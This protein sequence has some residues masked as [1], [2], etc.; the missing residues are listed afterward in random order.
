MQSHLTR[1]SAIHPALFAIIPIIT[2]VSLNLD[3]IFLENS[4]LLFLVIVPSVLVLWYLLN[5]LI[6]DKMKSGLLLSFGLVLFFSYGHFFNVLRDVVIEDLA[7]GRHRYLL[8]SFG[9][10]F[11]VGFYSIL[12]TKKNFAEF[13]TIANVI[14]IVILL[15]SVSNM[16]VYV[17]E[18]NDDNYDAILNNRLNYDSGLTADNLDYTPNV[19]YIIMDKYTSSKVLKDIFDFD[20]QDFTSQLSARGFHVIENSHSNYASTF[21]SLTSSLNMEYVN[22]LTDAVGI[23]SSNQKLSYQLYSDNN[24]MN[25]FKALNYTLVSS[26]PSSDYLALSGYEMCTD[27]L[28]RSQLNIILW[29][30]TILSPIFT[31]I[32][33]RFYAD[34]ILCQFSELSNLH[35][36]IEEPF[37]AYVHFLL[38]HQP[39]VFDPLG[40]FKEFQIN[41]ANTPQNLKLDYIDQV[42][43]AN[44][45]VIETIDKIL[46]ESDSPPIILL[47]GDHGTATLL[48][49]FGENW[50]NKNNESMTERMS[51][52]NAYYLPDQNTE[53]IIY[54]SITP[55]N[56]FRLILNAYF[57]TNYELL[58]DK[59]YFSDY[60]RPYNFTDVTKI[61]LTNST[62]N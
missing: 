8:P 18:N 40:N 1:S 13:T 16:F 44:K 46:L 12:K 52:L 32:S 58:E 56:S 11:A 38:P 5:L 19:Y 60:V 29:E 15:V 6:K 2:I 23:D 9:I 21:L 14:A 41:S 28:F 24:I 51:I 34:R 37:F 47:Q 36:S 59:S 61:L 7:I 26:Y 50:H 27:N 22:Y 4:A 17:L 45:K 48:T 39:Y 33:E 35:N 43:F 42:Q 53:L 31:I 25:I 55:V 57:N 54:D 20:N 62:Q 30:S 3:E 49:Q 10:I